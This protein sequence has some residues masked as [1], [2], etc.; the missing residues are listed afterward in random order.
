MNRICRMCHKKSSKALCVTCE[1]VKR[2]HD[3]VEEARLNA[4]REK[5]WVP[6]Q[7]ETIRT[8]S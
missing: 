3:A 8:R 6:P 5:G 7:V 2:H 4:L 1:R